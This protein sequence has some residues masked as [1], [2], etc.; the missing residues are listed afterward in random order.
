MFY[1]ANFFREIYQAL[2]DFEET[3]TH[4]IIKGAGGRSFC[5]G[6]DMRDIMVNP[7]T[8]IKE[9]FRNEYRSF[10]MIAEY[11][12]PF[13]ALIDG[14]CMGGACGFAM[15]GKTRIATERSVISMPE[16][17]V[18][19]FGASGSSYFLSRLRSNVGVYLAL[20][21]TRLRGFD[22]KRIGLA[23]HFG[24]LTISVLCA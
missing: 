4:V 18:G 21:G 14:V 9:R 19:F 3:K 12:K 1:V 22:L 23:T 17:S 16:T 5:I 7:L 8:V 15:L 2:K 24:E 11:K 6:R 10:Y 13:I 20:T